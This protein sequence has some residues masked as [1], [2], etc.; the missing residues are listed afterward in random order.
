MRMSID[1]KEVYSQDDQAKATSADH[2]RLNDSAEN[3]SSTTLP[4][5]IRELTTSSWIC[6]G[7]V[8]LLAFSALS[9]SL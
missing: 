8:V 3:A 7:T 5:Q 9:L 1:A 2:Q 6:T 4:V